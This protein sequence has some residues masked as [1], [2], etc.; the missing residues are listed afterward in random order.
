MLGDN[1]CLHRGVNRSALLS[2][3]K[4]GDLIALNRATVLCQ[5]KEKV[6]HQKAVVKYGAISATKKILTE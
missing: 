3:D 2:R 4:E 1:N 5:S 6:I